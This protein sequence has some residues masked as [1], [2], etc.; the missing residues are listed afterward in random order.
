MAL[1]QFDEGSIFDMKPSRSF[2]VCGFA[3][4]TC[5]PAAPRLLMPRRARAPVPASTSEVL[6]A[7]VSGARRFADADADGLLSLSFD[8]FVAI[9]PV[10]FAELRPRQDLRVWFDSADKDSDGDMSVDDY[11]LW[12]LDNVARKHGSEIVAELFGKYD[13]DGSGSVNMLEFH[14]ACDASGFGLVGHILFHALD[15]DGSGS[16]SYK[17]ICV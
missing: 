15:K 13:K 1:E 9:M 11:F 4:R 12:I 14:R 16:I 8:E 2:F 5:F 17:E 7:L 10:G 3:V 6:N